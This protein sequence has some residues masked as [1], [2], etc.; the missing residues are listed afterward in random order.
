MCRMYGVY[1]ACRVYEMVT[2]TLYVNK[3][4]VCLNFQIV[5]ANAGELFVKMMNYSD[6]EEQRSAAQTVWT[7]CFDKNVRSKIHPW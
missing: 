2:G 5:D 1:S 4:L 6:E 3:Q 7:L